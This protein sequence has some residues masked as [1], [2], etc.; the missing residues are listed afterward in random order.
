VLGNIKDL[1]VALCQ[2]GN[3]IAVLVA[4]DHIEHR[5]TRADVENGT[6]INRRRRLLA[7]LRRDGNCG[8]KEKADS[9]PGKA[10]PFLLDRHGKHCTARRQ[11]LLR[12]K[13]ERTPMCRTPCYKNQRTGTM[14]PARWHYFAK[15]PCLRYWWCYLTRNSTATS[16][17]ES[18]EL[19][20][21]GGLFLPSFS[22]QRSKS[23]AIFTCANRKCPSAVV[24]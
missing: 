11:S 10:F 21:L 3:S 4:H 5:F 24:V 12:K 19:T 1:E 16:L 17:R 20:V 6:G 2:I 23:S 18:H 15:L 8:G 14:V 13:F 7:L 22:A 9:C